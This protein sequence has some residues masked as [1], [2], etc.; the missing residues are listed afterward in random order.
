MEVILRVGLIVPADTPP[1]GGNVMSAQRLQ[2]GLA[3]L[4]VDATVDRWHPHLAPYDVYHAWNAVQVGQALVRHGLAPEKII[5]TWTGTDLWG[6]WVK[7]PAPIR[8][9]LKDIHRQ[10]VFTPNA[11]SRLLQDAPEWAQS[12]RVIPP[13]VDDGVFRPGTVERSLTPPWIVMAGGIRPVKQNAWAIDLVDQARRTLGYDLQLAVLGPVRD[14]GEWREVLRRAQNRAW[15]HI[16]GEVP[17]EAMAGWYQRATIVLNSSQIEGVSNALM[18]AMACGALIMATN[19]H[20]NRYLID[21]HKTGILFENVRDFVTELEWVLANPEA[22]NG[23]RHQARRR[24]AA[25]HLVQQEAE[26]YMALYQANS[27]NEPQQL[28]L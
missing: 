26:S 13:S 8:Y 22:A 17:K 16:V 27:R 18:E 5:V 20:G 25:Q 7:A 15:V 4:H 2:E 19:I 14:A 11:R 12:V 1:T 10:V 24:I 23:L 6:D 9:Q 3:R 21:P 28:S